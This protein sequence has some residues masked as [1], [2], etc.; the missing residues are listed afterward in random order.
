MVIN[1]EASLYKEEGVLESLLQATLPNFTG[2]KGVGVTKPTVN[3]QR[4]NSIQK[5]NFNKNTGLLDNDIEETIIACEDTMK[6]VFSLLG[7]SHLG[8]LGTF[9][10]S[11]KQTWSNIVTTNDSFYLSHF[12][13][14]VE[15]GAKYFITKDKE[16][17]N[18]DFKDIYINAF[19][20]LGEVSIKNFKEKGKF[21]NSIAQ[22]VY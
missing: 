10:N 1:T 5:I 21:I 6:G 2:N 4:R 11:I 15:Y 9:F 18:E 14:I 3:R 20:E 17:L 7:G 12:G 19:K 8:G 16:T 13:S 22:R